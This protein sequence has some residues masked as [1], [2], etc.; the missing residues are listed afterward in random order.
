MKFWLIK[1]IKIIIGL[2]S[3]ALIAVAWIYIQSKIAYPEQYWEFR[4]ASQSSAE[5]IKRGVFI[6]NLNFKIDSFSGD[7]LPF[8]GI[9]EKAFT[10]GKSSIDETILLKKTDF[11]YRLSFNSRPR[12]GI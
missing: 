1:N 7:S 12:A 4:K 5:S 3:L 2:L 6:K 11:P 10:Y 8:E 9:I